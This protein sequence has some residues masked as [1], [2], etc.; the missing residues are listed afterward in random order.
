LPVVSDGLA[1]LGKIYSL[2][3]SLHKYCTGELLIQQPPPRPTP[4]G[5]PSSAGF[6]S[7]NAFTG[8]MTPPAA[9]SIRASFKE[10]ENSTLQLY[11]FSNFDG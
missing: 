8:G 4:P 3:T 1:L 10:A 9:V 11:G 6:V 7:F 2:H 5:H